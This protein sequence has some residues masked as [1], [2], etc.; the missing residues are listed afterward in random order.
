M[1]RRIKSLC[2]LTTVVLLILSFTGCTPAGT[3]TVAPTAGPTATAAPEM[4]LEDYTTLMSLTCYQ[5]ANYGVAPK[6]LLNNDYAAYVRE[7]FKIDVSQFTWPTGEK[8]SDKIATMVAAEMIPDIIQAPLDKACIELINQMSDAG[9][10]LEVESYLNKY[11]PDTMKYFTPT[12]LDANRNPVDNKLYRI[13]GFTINP[14]LVS[15]L[16]VAVNEVFMYR[17]DLLKQ[18]G[19]EVPKT[20]EEFYEVLKAFSTMTAPDGSKL[21][22]YA[23]L[24]NASEMRTHIG[25]MFG[26]DRYRTATVEAEKR[27]TIAQ[28]QPEYL[29][30]LK[31][32]NKLYREG[33]IYADTYS[34]SWE[35]VYFELG[36][37][38]QVG[39]TQMWP[40]EIAGLTKQVQKLLPTAEYMP[41]PIPKAAG[42]T[43][44]E[45]GIQTSTGSSAI[46][47]SKDVADPDRLFKYLQWQSTN[48]GWA[49]A[50]WGPPSKEKGMWF[51]ENGLL[52]DQSKDWVDAKLAEDENFFKNNG[53]WA[54]GL[55][56]VYKYTTNLVLDVFNA[57]EPIRALAK[58]QYEPEIYLNPVYDVFAASPD[59]PIAIAKRADLR[60][61]LDEQEAKM[62]VGS[63]SDAEVEAAYQKMMADAVAAGLTDIEKEDYT[64]YKEIEAKYGK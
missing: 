17:T 8:A 63:K 13:P 37:Q 23:N 48:A 47:I 58:K 18:A 10:L 30:Y 46:V 9:M 28:E 41:M 42:V 22:P 52:V 4:K 50:T 16:S 59:G 55:V 32:A 3:P 57:P 40:S 12:I 5:G 38:G 64:R 14:E 29:T 1:K 24:W 49:T 62:I 11:A 15:E 35:K 61:I 39:M 6:D 25:A 45:M 26:I 51:I 54:Y 31:Y 60:K 33:L 2:I 34:T 19:L 53:A 20:P 36:P 21:V 44:S 56:G 43:S 27:M 7:N